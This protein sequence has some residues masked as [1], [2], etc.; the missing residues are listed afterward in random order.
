LRCQNSRLAS[1]RSEFW[2]FELTDRV[3]PPLDIIIANSY[4]VLRHVEHLIEVCERERGT[5]EMRRGG[6]VGL[7]KKLLSSLSVN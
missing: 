5:V 3:L 7:Q 2:N 1:C 4:S 6:Y